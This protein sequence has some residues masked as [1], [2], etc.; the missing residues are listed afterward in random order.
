[1]T[2]GGSIT[3]RI[4]R[5]RTGAYCLLPT[6]NISTFAPIVATLQG[7]D[8][9]AG[10][11]SVNTSFGSDCNA[12]DGWGVFTMDTTGKPADHQFVVAIM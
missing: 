1:M 11:I 12:D 5:I 4:H 8:F 9:T 6:P 7:P 10:L 2:R 3:I